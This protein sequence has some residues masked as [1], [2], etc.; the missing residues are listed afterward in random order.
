MLSFKKYISEDNNFSSFGK[1]DEKEI[2]KI[3]HKLHPTGCWLAYDNY[4]E[5]F[6]L[7]NNAD[8]AFYDDE[9][10]SVK[11]KKG[12]F[13]SMSSDNKSIVVT[14]MG[15]VYEYPASDSVIME[16]VPRRKKK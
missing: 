9:I 6:I 14:R 11:L 2:L 16:W 4:P 7:N 5:E 8:E 15:R 3:A 12:K 13:Y 10:L 1:Y